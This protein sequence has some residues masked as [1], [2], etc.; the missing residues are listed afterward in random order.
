MIGNALLTL[1][2]GIMNVLFMFMGVLPDIDP[3]INTAIDAFFDFM[4][5]GINLVGVFVDIDMIKILIPVV[6]L[7]IR[8]DDIIKLVMFVL[9]KIPVLGIK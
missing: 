1:G 7:I 3:R 5:A 2:E 6:I 8:A 4:F 9:K